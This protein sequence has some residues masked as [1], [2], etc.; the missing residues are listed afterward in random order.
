MPFG[1]IV[2]ST[3]FCIPFWLIVILFIQARVTALEAVIFEGIA[4]LGLM[5]FLILFS[6][7]K[8]ERGKQYRLPSDPPLKERSIHKELKAANK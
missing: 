7:P 2:W 8:T 5:L 3:I 4:L 1:G 6:P